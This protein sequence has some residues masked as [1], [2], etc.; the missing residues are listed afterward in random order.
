MGGED[1]AQVGGFASLQIMC[2]CKYRQLCI[3][4]QIYYTY[5]Y[6]KMCIDLG[7]YMN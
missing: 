5:P 2:V 3:H 6:L 7:Q 1:R 4:M